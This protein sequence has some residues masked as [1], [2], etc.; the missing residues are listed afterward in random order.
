MSERASTPR[1]DMG[2][3]LVVAAG[4]GLFVA[5]FFPWFRAADPATPD[6]IEAR[7]G[8][9]DPSELFSIA[10]VLIGVALAVLVVLWT[11]GTLP[12]W[13][14]P[15]GSAGV[16][17]AGALAAG[18]ALA[19]KWLRNTEFDAEPGLWAGLALGVVL[20]AGAV[21]HL[22]ETRRRA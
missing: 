14:G 6:V 21:L 10:A 18:A 3:W 5:S 19:V 16:V 11:S 12:A 1:L 13:S 20:C 9:S 15:G 17:L 8:W 22:W 2:A 7:N 4:A